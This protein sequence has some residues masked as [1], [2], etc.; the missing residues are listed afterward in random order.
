[1]HLR[2]L[3]L[4]KVVSNWWLNTSLFNKWMELN[5]S[6]LEIKFKLD[7]NIPN[8]LFLIAK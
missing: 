4:I 7:A 6:H 2:F 5:T 8:I 1:M 3:F